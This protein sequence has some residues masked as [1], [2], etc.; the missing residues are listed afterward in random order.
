MKYWF[1]SCLLLAGIGACKV[2]K[3]KGSSEALPSP[4][5]CTY[6]LGLGIHNGTESVYN[7][8]NTKKISSSADTIEGATYKISGSY[9]TNNYTQ[10]YELTFYFKSKP[11]QGTYNLIKGK[12]IANDADAI[13][14]ISDPF[15]HFAITTA[16]RLRVL[17]DG[18]FSQYEF[19]DLTF[20]STNGLNSIT[21][22]G[23]VNINP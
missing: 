15:N 4:L 6:V 11:E 16:S 7:N 5:S 17:E 10:G 21:T 19:C 22:S 1:I 13:V 9:V 14:V 20:K 3:L 18:G 2:K 23:H 8:L 12:K